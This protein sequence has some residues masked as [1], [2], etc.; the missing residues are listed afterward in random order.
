MPGSPGEHWKRT[1]IISIVTSKQAF[2]YLNKGWERE[3]A[4]NS[5]QNL[6]YGS[7][8]KKQWLMG[9]WSY[10]GDRWMKTFTSGMWYSRLNKELWAGQTG[11]SC[12]SYRGECKKDLERSDWKCLLGSLNDILVKHSVTVEKKKWRCMR[13]VR[14]LSNVILNKNEIP[15]PSRSPFSLFIFIPACPGHAVDRWNV[16]RRVSEASGC[17]LGAS[18]QTL[19]PSL[20]DS[21][22]ASLCRAAEAKAWPH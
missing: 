4:M 3:I 5:L 18:S 12:C 19:K 9:S 13:W 7:G 6:Q 10:H 15:K 2:H 14:Y 17:Q 11:W 1:E 16:C 22:L 8:E 21:R 20:S